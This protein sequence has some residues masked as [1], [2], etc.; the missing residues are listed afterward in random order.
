[1]KTLFSLFSKTIYNPQINYKE[2][3]PDWSE[4]FLDSADIKREFTEQDNF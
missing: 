4:P 1:M 3:D 2:S